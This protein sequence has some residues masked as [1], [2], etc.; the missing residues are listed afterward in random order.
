MKPD[1]QKEPD[2]ALEELFNSPE[3]KWEKLKELMEP[4]KDGCKTITTVPD[5]S[6]S[7]D[8]P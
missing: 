3:W 1:A 5:E 2:K 4:T 7:G 6:K 8:I